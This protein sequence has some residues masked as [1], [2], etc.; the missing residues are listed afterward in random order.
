MKLSATLKTEFAAIPTSSFLPVATLL[1][2]APLLEASHV[3]IPNAVSAVVYAEMVP[4]S[5]LPFPLEEEEEEDLLLLSLLPDNSSKL[6]SLK[7]EVFALPMPAVLLPRPAMD[8]LVFVNLTLT[9]LYPILDREL[10]SNNNVE[11]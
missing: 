1:K 9:W 8:P 11:I 4:V 6:V 7:K 3:L 5:L 2:D 10:L